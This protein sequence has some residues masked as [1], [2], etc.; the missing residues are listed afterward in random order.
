VDRYSK[1][2]LFIPCHKEDSAMDTA[3]LFWNGVLPRTGLPRIIISDRDPKFTSEFWTK[4]HCMLGTKLSFSTAYHP[5]TDGLAERMIKT[6][7]D[8]IRRFCAYGLDFKDNKGFTHDWVSLLPILELAYSTS[9]HSSTGKTPA[10][11]ER[12]WTP[13]LP[14]H[15]INDKIIDIHPTAK[16]YAQMFEK[17]KKHAEDCIELAAQYNKERWDK[18][19]KEPEFKIGDKVLV[20]TVNFNNLSGPQKMRN[21]FAGPFLIKALHG[22]NAVEVILT[23]EFSRKH[24]TFLVSL[25]KHYHASDQEKFSDRNV[26]S[27]TPTPVEEDTSPGII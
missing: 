9:I 4:L 24:P 10:M 3:I 8:M 17:T 2:L 22:K 11:L 16:K 12:G 6:L 13:R 27:N 18:S 25:I 19:H 5:Q 7:E 1:T 20:S 15:L 21:S 26:I 23:E 14:Q